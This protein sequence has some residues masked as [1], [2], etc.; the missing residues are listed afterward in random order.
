M[1]LP[2][3]GSVVGGL[4]SAFGANRAARAQ[5]SASA[6]QLEL[7]REQF[8]YGRRQ[9]APFYQSGVNYLNAYDSEV[10]GTPAPTFGGRAPRVEEYTIG[11]PVSGAPTTGQNVSTA[12]AVRAWAAGGP[13]PS[14]IRGGGDGGMGQTNNNIQPTARTGFRV[15]GQ[16]FDTREAAQAYANSQATGGTQ[17]GGYTRT[18]GYEFRLN[19]G[20]D[21]IMARQAALGSLDS[22]ETG[23]ALL[24]Y[25]Q[26]YATSEYDRHLNRLAQGA[27]QGQ[28]AAIMQVNN[29]QNF[30]NTATNA[31]ANRG[32]AQA[33]GAVGVSNAINSG[34]GNAIGAWQYQ[35]QR[36]GNTYQA[37][38]QGQ[39]WWQGVY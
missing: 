16:E 26:D 4:F 34:I 19:E 1:S 30:L 23:R 22:G 5:E 20:L 6:D 11:T 37:P 18:P 13:R 14:F 3:L 9:I 36:A 17:Y 25:G 35:N 21:A 2:I 39:S 15:G 29:G 31:I 10:L 38:G 24:Q 8:N 32:D 7:A 12:D 28:G 27:A 33:A